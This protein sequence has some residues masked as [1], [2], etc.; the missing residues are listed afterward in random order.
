[1]IELTEVEWL[2]IEQAARGGVSGTSDEWPALVAAIEKVRGKPLEMRR[3]ASWLRGFCE[4]VIIQ[5]G[6][7][8]SP[9]ST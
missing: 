5:S 3:S 9:A 6:R 1:M 2:Q 8:E 4:G 7:I